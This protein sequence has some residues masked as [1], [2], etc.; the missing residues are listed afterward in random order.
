MAKEAISKLSFFSFIILFRIF[1]GIVL[2]LLAC[3]ALFLNRQFLF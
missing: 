1:P 3:T 2:M